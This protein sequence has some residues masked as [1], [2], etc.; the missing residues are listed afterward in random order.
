M[1]E[2][3]LDP[4]LDQQKVSLYSYTVMLL[5]KVYTASKKFK[6][7]KDHFLKIFLKIYTKSQIFDSCVLFYRLHVAACIYVHIIWALT[8]KN[9]SSGLW[10]NKGADQPSHPRRLISTFFI[11]LSERIISR[12]ATSEIQFSI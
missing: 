6:W 7:G 5:L 9:L 10:D 8:R 12:L 2:N 1:F 11:H 4:D 3:S